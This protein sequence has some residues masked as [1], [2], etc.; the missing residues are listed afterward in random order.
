MINETTELYEPVDS[1]TD[2][3]KMFGRINNFMVGQQLLNK[4]VQEQLNVAKKMIEILIK[5]H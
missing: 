3:I 1:D 5:R 2:E 4:N